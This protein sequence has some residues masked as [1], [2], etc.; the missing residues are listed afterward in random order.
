MNVRL[1]NEKELK[2]TLSENKVFF[3]EFFVGKDVYECKLN[4]KLYALIPVSKNTELRRA[5]KIY[6]PH[7]TDETEYVLNANALAIVIDAYLDDGN[8]VI[9]TDVFDNQLKT[10]EMAGFKFFTKKENL[11]RYKTLNRGVY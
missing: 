8:T 9:Y 10:F 6:P 1:L 4:N 2:I 7:F 11:K 3:R 5:K